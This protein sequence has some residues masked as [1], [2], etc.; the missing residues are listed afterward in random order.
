[1]CQLS[2]MGLCLGGKTPLPA[3]THG[4]AGDIHTHSELIPD[5]MQRSPLKIYKS[6]SLACQT[7][8]HVHMDESYTF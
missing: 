3:G 5:Y 2:Q 6:L 1:M 7:D 4:G 8:S